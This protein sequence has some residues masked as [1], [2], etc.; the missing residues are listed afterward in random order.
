MRFPAACFKSQT[1]IGSPFTRLW[2]VVS[3]R[4]SRYTY[5]KTRRSGSPTGVILRRLNP[6]GY[7]DSS[8]GNT[9]NKRLRV[10]RT[11]SFSR[12]RYRLGS[13][14]HRSGVETG[15]RKPT[16]DPALALRLAPWWYIPSLCLDVSSDGI[17]PWTTGDGQLL[18]HLWLATW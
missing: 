1:E 14:G 4:I 5:S 2:M 3:G 9:K 10:A 17:H 16:Y 15:R 11:S 8:C 7:S 13:S 6:T 12:R 18:A